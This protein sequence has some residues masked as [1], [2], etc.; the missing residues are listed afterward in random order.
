MIIGDFIR[1]MTVWNWLAVIAFMIALVSFV[2]AFLSL[3]A[4]YRDWRGT[5]SKAAF[6]KRLEQLRIQWWM[7]EVYKDNST[8]YF[9]EVCSA[10]ASLIPGILSAMT[11]FLWAYLVSGWIFDF[12]KIVF[13]LLGILTLTFEGK[14]ARR[15][16]QLTYRVANPSTFAFEI[17]GFVQNAK[18]KD[19]RSDEAD[20]LIRTIWKSDV[21]NSIDK[22]V[23][24]GYIAS[25]LPELVIEKP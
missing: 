19:L 10:A 24:Q 23:V 7:L 2:N 5:K 25:Q 13:V 1:S 18:T 9:R 15:L 11:L 3:K 22:Q 12:G 16:E 17:V 6:E 21:L 20:K 14:R 4:R 8:K